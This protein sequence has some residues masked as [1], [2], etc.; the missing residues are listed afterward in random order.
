[1]AVPSC[2]GVGVGRLLSQEQAAIAPHAFA[3]DAARTTYF[4]NIDRAINCVTIVVQV[5]LTRWLLLRFGVG[6][7]LLI[8]VFAVLGGYCLLAASPLPMLIAIVQV[9]TRAGEFSLGKPARET[10]YT[11]VEREWRYKAKAAIDTFVYRGSDLSFVWLHKGLAAFGSHVVFVV[12]VGAAAAMTFGAWQ[13]ARTQRSLP[14]DIT[15]GDVPH[16]WP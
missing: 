16:D 12:G 13:V 10:I 15:P 3:D 6:T 11:R 4:A 1:L 2:F 9:L 8:P 14:S 7:T 5:F